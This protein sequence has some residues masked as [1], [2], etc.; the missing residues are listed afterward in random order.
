MANLGKFRVVSVDYRQGYEH[1]FPA[2]SEDVCAVYEELLKT[3]APT[4][5]GP[6]ARILERSPLGATMARLRFRRSHD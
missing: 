5:I 1:K 6:T 2:A 3:F 4:Q